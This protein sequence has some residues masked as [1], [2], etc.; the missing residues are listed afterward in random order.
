[1]FSIW[2]ANA[3]KYKVAWALCALQ[4][5]P[6]HCSDLTYVILMSVEHLRLFWPP[7]IVSNISNISFFYTDKFVPKRILPYLQHLS[8]N[9]IQMVTLFTFTAF[10]ILDI[11]DKACSCW[12][13]LTF[14]TRVCVLTHLTATRYMKHG[15]ATLKVS[16]NHP[17][18]RFPF[19][20]DFFAWRRLF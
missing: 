14:T 18:K 3:F 17:W 20:K 15:P 9:A 11:H 10:N 2:M 19:S 4:L 8:I 6:S 7:D 12:S 13:T 16:I 1:M 5:S